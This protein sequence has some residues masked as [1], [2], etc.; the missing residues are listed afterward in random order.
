MVVGLARLGNTAVY[1]VAVTGML[2]RSRSETRNIEPGKER[3]NRCRGGNEC[4][5]VSWQAEGDRPKRNSRLE[6]CHPWERIRNRHR[7]Q[8]RPSHRTSHE[9]GK[10]MSRTAETVGM[11]GGTRLH[12]QMSGVF[13]GRGPLAVRAPRN[14]RA[15]RAKLPGLLEAHLLREVHSSTSTSQACVASA[16]PLRGVECHLG[17]IPTLDLAGRR[18]ILAVHR[19]RP[20]GIMRPMG[21][22]CERIRTLRAVSP[23]CLVQTGK[24]TTRFTTGPCRGGTETELGLHTRQGCS[25]QCLDQRDILLGRVTQPELLR[26]N[27]RGRRR[28]SGL[29]SAST[30]G[31]ECLQTAQASSVPLEGR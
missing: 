21:S 18:T 13:H 11:R 20:R 27:A 3:S 15:D 6:E 2:V 9:E 28:K 14:S 19:L 17:C 30:L 12:L 7:G 26:I 22:A 25:S 5:R 24:V 1:L 10:Q 8:R 31:C 29:Q 4:G 23:V 16:A